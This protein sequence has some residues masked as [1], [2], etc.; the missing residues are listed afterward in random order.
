MVML[1]SLQ[2]V[3]FL[4]HGNTEIRQIGLYFLCASKKTS[5]KI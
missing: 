5:T 2:L 1:T 4:H 3:E